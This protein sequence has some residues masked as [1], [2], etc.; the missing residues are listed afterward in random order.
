MALTIEGGYP[1]LTLDLGSGPQRII[2]NRQVSDNIWRQLIVERTGRNVKLIVREDEGDSGE[3]TYVTEQS[4]PGSHSVF[5][6]DK[7]KS[8]LFVGGIPP[9]FQVQDAVMSS[10]FDGDME[11]LMI[12]EIPL[13]FFNFVYGENNGQ[14]AWERDRL[15]DLHPVTG[16]RFEKDGYALLRKTQHQLPFDQR[17]FRVQFMFKTRSS[18]GLMF[19][20][21]GAKHFLSIGMKEGH[22]LY[23]FELD[24]GSVAIKSADK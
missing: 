12:G 14:P 7:E 13:S 17:K 16:Y 15:V 4:M 6:L 21:G 2:G 9:S 8:K 3:Q 20:M 22:V 18:D 23:Q 19:L 10:S 1:V 5:N 24:D 11:E